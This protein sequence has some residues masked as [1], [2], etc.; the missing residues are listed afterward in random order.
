ME[1]LTRLLHYLVHQMN[2]R[3]LTRIDAD[4]VIPHPYPEL[5]IPYDTY[6]FTLHADGRMERSG[7]PVTGVLDR[8]RLLRDATNH[9]RNRTLTFASG[10]ISVRAA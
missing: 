2:Q 7:V 8:L 3:G 5:A 6:Q 10:L 4:I 1:D 9:R